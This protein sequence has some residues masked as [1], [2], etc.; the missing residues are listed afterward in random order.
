MTGHEFGELPTE[1]DKIPPGLECTIR[2]T[3]VHRA[4]AKRTQSHVAWC[5]HIYVKDTNNPREVM[6]YD[7]ELR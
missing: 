2:G 3:N 7:I 1:H 5:R 6:K 4:S